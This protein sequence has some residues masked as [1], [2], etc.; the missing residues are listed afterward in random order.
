MFDCLEAVKSLRMLGDTCGEAARLRTDLRRAEDKLEA[1]ADYAA[2]Q[3]RRI[4]ALSYTT[5]VTFSIL[6]I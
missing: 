3:T 2:E 1:E 6:H 4:Y 5:Q